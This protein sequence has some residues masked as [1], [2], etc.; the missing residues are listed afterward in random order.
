[1]ST[2]K[3]KFKIYSDLDQYNSLTEKVIGC[4]YK[5]R[6]TLGVGFLEKVYENALAHE[7][8]KQ[9]IKVQQQA[10]MAVYYDG[11]P[12]GDYFADLF[13]DDSIIVELKAVTDLNDAH[14]AQCMNYLK[15]SG[16][17][18]CLLINMGSKQVQIRRT[19]N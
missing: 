18:L 14:A 6:N 10:P 3:T 16:L 5:V 13:V 19:A 7:L 1:M 15:A 9:G 4:A 17:R 8:N 12:I 2:D 11:A